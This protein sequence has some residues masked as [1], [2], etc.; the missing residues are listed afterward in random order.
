MKVDDVKGKHK[1]RRVHKGRHEGTHKLFKIRFNRYRVVSSSTNKLMLNN[2]VE[3]IHNYMHSIIHK[4][5]IH[6]KFLGLKL[7]DVVNNSH[8]YEVVKLNKTTRSQQV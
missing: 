3:L 4:D 2:H 5:I 1:G 7:R 6:F 8:L